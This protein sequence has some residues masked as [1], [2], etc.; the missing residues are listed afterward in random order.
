MGLTDGR[1]YILYIFFNNIIVAYD[2]G[3]P[4]QV[5]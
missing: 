4:W 5:T 3:I 2:D 1:M